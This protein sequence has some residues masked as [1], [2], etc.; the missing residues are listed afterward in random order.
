M[1]AR[2]LNYLPTLQNLSRRL[3]SRSEKDFLEL[4]FPAL[5]TTVWDDDFMG[6]LF[7]GG[8]APGVY[9]STASGANSAVAA[10]VT[11]VVN[12]V[13][14][15][16]PGDANSGR[17]DLSL[18]LHFQAQLNPV[19]FWR[20]TLPDAITAAK[21]ELGFTD[22]ISGTDAGAVN[23]KGGNTWNASDAAVLCF[24]TSDD[25]NVTLMGVAATVAATVVDM[26]FTLAAD[27]YYWF[28]V[29]LQIE[30]KT[31]DTIR[32]KGIILNTDGAKI[33]ESAWMAD[34]VAPTTLLTPWAFVQNR[35]A[36][37]RRMR[38]DRVVAYQRKTTG[39]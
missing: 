8:A 25:T 21:F 34:A 6:D 22:V 11:G 5:N 20:V 2:T 13:I 16:D 36:A 17:S 39:S 33:A 28:G 37:Q 18:G 23:S 9:Q 35:S 32:A 31:T 3:G 38:I 10:I 30:D 29:A 14:L 15:L 1:G 26:D 19:C 24:D 27:T 4:G 12:G 7:K